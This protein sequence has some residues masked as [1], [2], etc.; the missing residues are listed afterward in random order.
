MSHLER[1]SRVLDFWEKNKIFERSIDQRSPD[2]QFVFYD[3]P[4]FATGLPHYGNIL[5]F[6]SKDLF[7]RYWTMKGFRCER[8]WGWDC[9]GLP[10]ENI[11]ENE[12]K[13]KEKKE[14]V[15]MGVESFNKYCRSRVLWF[16]KEW[17]EFIKRMGKWIDIDAAYKTMDVTYMETVWHIFKTLYDNGLIYEGKRILLYCP[18]CETPLSKFE[19]AMDNSYKDVSEPAITVKFKIASAKN[20]YLLAW[21]TT[22]WTL[23]GNVALAVNAE[24]DY[25]KVQVQDDFLIMI[26]NAVDVM[27]DIKAGTYK[28]VEELKGEKLVGLRYNPLFQL[29]QV[30]DG[31][32]V[33]DGGNGI[34]AEEGTGVVHI[35]AYGEFD[36]EVIQKNH[37]SFV[38]HIGDDGRLQ[39]GPEEWFGIWFK[40]L[41]KKVIGDLSHRGLLYKS[42]EHVHSY[43]FC[44]RCDTPLIFN[45][46]NS[47]FVNIQAIKDRLLERAKVIAWYPSSLKVAFENLI[48]AA[49]DWNISRNRFWATAIPIW[50]CGN[51]EAHVVFGSVKELK[52]NAIELVPD[53]M[54]LHKDVVDGIHVI[55][56]NCGSTM[57]RIPEVFDC[58]LESGSMPFAAKHYPFE[59]Q[60]FLDTSF[61]CD[62]VS[63]YIAQVRAWFYYMLVVATA[64]VDKAP[65]KN[66][67]VTG[68]ILA[69]DGKKMSKSKKNF[70]DPKIILDKYGGDALRFF[71]FTSPVMR[72]EDVN[73]VESEL[74]E[75][76]KNVILLLENI[77]RFYDLFCKGNEIIDDSGSPHVMDRWIL[78]RL[79]MVVK[80]VTSYLDE[81]NSVATCSEITAFIE[82]LS[83]WYIRRSRDRFKEIGSDR[84]DNAVKTLG[85]VLWVFS[86][87]IAP[88]MPFIAENIYQLVKPGMKNYPESVHLR[89]WPSC[90][91]I[92]IDVKL[93][94]S[95]QFVRKIVNMALEIRAKERIPVRQALAGLEVKGARLD[96]DYLEIIADEVNVKKVSVV[97]DPVLSVSMDLSITAELKMEGIFRDLIRHVNQCRKGMKLQFTNE[98]ILYFQSEDQDI[99]STIRKFKEQLMKAIHARDI[100]ENV[101]I[102]EEYEEF[103]VNGSPVKIAI[104]RMS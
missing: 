101:E 92:L 79:N 26:K 78:S 30:K 32:Y 58:W 3:G 43:P 12:L 36:M 77:R 63:E 93:M 35:A 67:V 100:I 18:R 103:V 16:A 70:P 13:I 15:K 82:D 52:D 81:Y 9:H 72:G 88:L 53:D 25:V 51:C 87:V 102:Q 75:T 31:Y 73:F 50:R 61:P 94:D 83:T 71:L 68:N 7:P 38:Q 19:I 49:P 34:T 85:H 91:E 47:W 44:Y 4:P 5:G 96:E 64:F 2:K 90:N 8:R 23:I 86:A 40:E 84:K 21:T 89:D 27:P 97:D 46:I 33:V 66:I 104:K 56:K 55:C 11:A 65:F 48:R 95:M 80:K 45:A 98:I 20:T 1:E 17:K 57:S 41:D 10:I 29:D 76:Y 54:D 42:Q 74:K 59:S 28:I 69:A 39:K 14:I 37:I 99:K 24:F 60:G 62:F 22:P 6:I